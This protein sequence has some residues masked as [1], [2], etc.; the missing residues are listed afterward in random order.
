[1]DRDRLQQIAEFGNCEEFAVHVHRSRQ[2][3]LDRRR[4]MLAGMDGVDSGELEHVN[5][6]RVAFFKIERAIQI[7]FY[8]QRESP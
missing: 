1:M 7:V 2:C 5:I 6:A 3:N 4:G 8:E